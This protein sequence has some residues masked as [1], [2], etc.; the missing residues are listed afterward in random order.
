[1]QWNMAQYLDRENIS[2]M[3]GVKNLELFMAKRIPYNYPK[4]IRS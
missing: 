1:M 3:V 4:I 2:M